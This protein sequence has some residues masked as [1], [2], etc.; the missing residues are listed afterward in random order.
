MT[1]NDPPTQASTSW[2]RTSK[3]RDVRG[4]ALILHGLNFRPDRMAGIAEVLNN[5]GI[6]CL[7]VALAGH[8]P[9]VPSDLAGPISQD[10]TSNAAQLEEFRSVSRS[11]WLAET[12]AAYRQARCWADDRGVPLILGAFSLGAAVGCDLA[13]D[14]ESEAYFDG[15]I[16][17]APAL[18]IHWYT[19]FLRILTPFPRLALKSFS[20]VEYAANART[21]IAA[22]RALMDSIIA[23]KHRDDRWME[24]D[25]LGFVDP[26][27][28]LVSH[29][30]LQAIFEKKGAKRW[31]LIEVPKVR[32]TGIRDY[33]HLIVDESSV[34]SRLWGE[35]VR[36]IEAFVDG[37]RR[38]EGIGARAARR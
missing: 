31:R 5:R 29:R 22:Y 37:L 21:P 18:S 23:I 35:V 17:F 6:D 2:I 3:S 28:E 25:V 38:S 10:T 1:R 8:R 4:V 36:H 7:N 12:D 24:L 32:R 26:Q 34:G 14:P 33:H 20:P 15:M 13:S 19:H 30:G 16:L 9:C 11:I 27:D